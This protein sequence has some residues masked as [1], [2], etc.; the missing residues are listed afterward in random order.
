MKYTTN[1]NAK[2]IGIFL[3]GMIV[4]PSIAQDAENLVPNGSFESLDK[5]PKKLGSIENAKGWYSPTGVRA[6]LFVPSKKAPDVD[7]PLNVYGKEDAKDGSNYAGIVGFSYNDKV[8]RTYLSTKLSVPMKKGT[9]Y[10]VQF[11]VSMAE[12][13]KYASNQIGMNISKKAFGTEEKVSIIDKA[14]VLQETNKIFD[15]AYNW[16]QVC[17]IYEAEGGEKYITIG[18]FSTNEDTKNERNKKVSDLKIAQIIAAYYYI[19]N[20][21]ITLMDDTHPCTC[22]TIDET[23]KYSKTIYQRV[24]KTNDKMTDSQLIEANILFFGFAKDKISQ[25]GEDALNLIAEKMKANPT[26]KLQISGFSDVEEEKL[27]VEKSYYAGMDSKRVNAI[28]LYLIDKG[29]AEGRLI[30]SPQGSSEKSSEISETDDDDIK[31]AK[32]RRVEFKVR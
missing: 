19:D 20:V 18:N 21:S 25:V 17:G 16:E 22:V 5:D 7:V 4:L 24:P 2:T 32:N 14:N 29:V 9:R 13:S 1:I 15:A 8:P 12:A 3:L 30:L 6:D 26:M 27:G 31:Q 28:A 11:N 10:C 23:D